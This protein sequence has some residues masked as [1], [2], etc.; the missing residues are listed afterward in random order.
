MNQVAVSTQGKIQQA[1]THAADSL[2][3]CQVY[4]FQNMLHRVLHKMIGTKLEHWL[5]EA[6][7]TVH[8]LK[9]INNLF[10]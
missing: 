2:K 10:F 8:L 1:A 4:S 5:K 6:E 9:S 3:T 7:V